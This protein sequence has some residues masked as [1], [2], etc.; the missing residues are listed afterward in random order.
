MLVIVAALALANIAASGK[1]TDDQ[2]SGTRP[3]SDPDAIPD[4]KATN[5][6]K[7]H[8]NA[9]MSAVSDY[10][11]RGVSQTAGLAAVQAS[12]EAVD[13]SGVY[14]GTWGSVTIPSRR[15]YR[16]VD[17]YGGYRTRIGVVDF[18]MGIVS[19]FYP[20]MSSVSSVETYASGARAIGDATVKMG[21][22]YT[23]HQDRLGVGDGLYLFAE[24]EKALPRTPVVM[25]GHIGR[26]T[27][28]NTL[29]GSTKIDWLLGTEVNI[30]YATIS[31]AWVDARYEGRRRTMDSSGRAVAAVAFNF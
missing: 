9:N 8:F 19:Y 27:G 6:D 30:S 18:D 5:D 23:P 22:S 29:T 13:R 11:F 26:E 16:E 7:S 14:V 21:V 3:N 17:L 25:R 1:P 10:R 2:T 24:V 4:G 28:V 15:A 12:V 31:L 20:A